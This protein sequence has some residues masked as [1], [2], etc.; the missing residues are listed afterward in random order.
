[1]NLSQ[2]NKTNGKI[3]V[4]ATPIGNLADI[5]FRALEVLRKV[6]FI[7]CE[8][9]RITK[10]LLDRYNIHKPLTIVNARN[11][12]YCISEIINK[13]K[14]G[15]SCALVSD[16]GTPLISDPGS[17]LINEAIKNGIEIIAVPGPSAITAAL[18]ISGLPSSSFVFEGF[19]PQKKGRQKKLK[20]L[21]NEDRTIVLFESPY[22][23]KN[24]LEELNK[25]MPERYIIICRELTKKFEEVWRG[26]P[27]T[28]L[29]ELKEK[30]I[31]GEFVVIISPKNWVQ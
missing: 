6:D 2:L 9:T 17:K 3:F 13:L 15:K 24:L 5:T 19:L 27:S 30:T 22:R 18:S 29:S 25:Y 16:A 8:D 20:E 12:Y 14:T 23:I 1:M 10:I 11:E 4:V 28:L 7:A 26:T 21:C 31:K